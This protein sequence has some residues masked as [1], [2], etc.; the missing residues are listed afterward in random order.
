VKAFGVRPYEGAYAKIT[1]HLTVVAQGS[2][3]D[4]RPVAR[5]LA[6]Q[7]PISALADRVHLMVGRQGTR[8]TLLRSTC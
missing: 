6:D 7:L 8:W 5:A 2:P 1:P 4:A 3:E